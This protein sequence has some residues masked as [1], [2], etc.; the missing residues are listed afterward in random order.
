MH[1]FHLK[2]GCTVDENHYP[3][4]AYQTTYVSGA[5]LRLNHYHTRSQ[6]EWQLKRARPRADTGVVRDEYFGP[7]L[8]KLL[9]QEDK[10]GTEDRAILQYLPALRR[11]VENAELRANLG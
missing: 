2:Q 8:E 4:R 6:E 7:D 11:A 1:N 5:R 3:V 9:T 10:F